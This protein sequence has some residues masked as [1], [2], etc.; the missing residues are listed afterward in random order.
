MKLAQVLS[1][2]ESSTQILYVYKEE[3]NPINN[4]LQTQIIK[5]D[6]IREM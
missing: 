2:F 5:I 1:I 3:C 4:E 6:N